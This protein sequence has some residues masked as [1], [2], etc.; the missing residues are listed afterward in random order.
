M[1]LPPLLPP[2]SAASDVR[3][4]LTSIG[5]GWKPPFMGGGGLFSVLQLRQV[6]NN[7]LLLLH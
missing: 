7:L 1:L 3:L 4:L 5:E 2:L 6:A